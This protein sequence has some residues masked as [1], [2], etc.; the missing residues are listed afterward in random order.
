[1][2][3]IKAAAGKGR[4]QR[5]NYK[6]IADY[7]AEPPPDRPAPAANISAVKSA[8]SQSLAPALSHILQEVRRE[9]GAEGTEV[10][11]DQA[12]Q[13][14][15]QRV[16]GRL[17]LELTSY[18]RDEILSQ[19]ESDQKPFGVLQEL[20]DDSQVSD[21]IVTS[22]SKITVQQGRRNYDTGLSFPDHLSY[23]NFVE[24][25]LQRAGS[26]YSTKKPIAD[27]M[28]GAF[29]RIHAVHKS[30]CESGPYLTIRFNRFSSVGVKDLVK[31]GLA[32][33]EIFDYLSAV[34]ATG[35]TVLVVGEVGTGKT[36]L[37]RALAATIPEEEAVLVIEDTPE[38][39]L[40]HPQVRYLTTREANTD[41]AGRVSPG[42]CIRGGMRMAMNRIIFGEMRDAEAAEA[43]IDVCASGHPGLSTIHAKSAAEAITRLELFLGRAQKGVNRNVLSEQI[44]TAVQVIVFVN[45]CKLTGKRRIIQVKEIG[46]VADGVVRSRDMFAY[47]LSNGL[48]GWKVLNKVSAHREQ[49][50]SAGNGVFLSRMPG[51]L[52]LSIES[53]YREAAFLRS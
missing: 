47:Q 53:Q 6:A 51:V 24:K 35:N 1:M 26:S 39:R 9:L 50:E 20:A 32:P 17:G 16:A 31:S 40:E 29:A 27:G 25:L 22:Y 28:I 49:I 5:I 36:T 52:E 23:E 44:V 14:I 30:I 18:E 41:G 15:L 37:V 4:M 43:F 48:P 10:A 21:I 38:I 3:A 19:I 8:A 12:V 45:I 7:S 11:D 33:Q 46:P 42:E 34:I 2:S 13:Q